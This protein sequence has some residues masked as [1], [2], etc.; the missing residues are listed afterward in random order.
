MSTQVER[1]SS[2]ATGPGEPDCLDGFAHPRKQSDFHGHSGAVDA[3]VSARLSSKVHHAWLFSGP[4]GIG[5]ATLAYRF[6]RN[7]L[8]DP[9]ATGLKKA[10][11]L[12]VAADHPV[13]AQSAAQAHPGLLVLRR[14]WQE[15]TKR[16]ASE[17]TVGE[18]RRLRAFFNRTAS[19]GSWRVVI[20]DRAEDLNT[21]AANALLKSLEEPP[22]RCIFL[23]VCSAPGRLPVTVRSRCRTLMF[24]PL[25]DSEL[26]DA[27]ASA[28]RS[29][30]REMPGPD[31]ITACLPLAQGSVE[32]AL[33][34]L[35]GG[36]SELHQRLI[37]LL[38]SLPRVDHEAVHVLADDLSG[39]SADTTYE[40]FFE[41][42]GET[43]A[44]IVAHGATGSGA[45]GKEAEISARLE[46]A[47]A[48]AKFA[49]LWETVR[50]AKAEAD[51]LNL[52][53]KN[54]VL[55]TFF[56]LEEA[57]REAFVRHG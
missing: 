24:H 6:A 22:A 19:G 39:I 33:R 53:R 51:A 5:K 26:R 55:G 4:S 38:V 7:L 15:K 8:A 16:F 23:L 34:L 57:A 10:D 11:R 30:E 36:G 29:A 2:D 21:A 1:K 13:W 25:G 27:I 44:R 56:R 12:D 43:I 3:L 35:D 20:I 40:L 28:Y 50:R 49:Q 32:R 18:V 52:D 9:D 48:L 46:N 31:E 41:L 14:P 17:I 42:V 54:L 37:E 45:I 47:A